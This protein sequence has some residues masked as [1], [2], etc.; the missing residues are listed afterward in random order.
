MKR[1]E[2]ISKIILFLGLAAVGVFYLLNEARL[3]ASDEEW[4]R[5][6]TTCED[7]ACCVD[8]QQYR[9]VNQ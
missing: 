1:F 3:S 5:E 2:E 9:G 4:C 6:F 7:T 8:A